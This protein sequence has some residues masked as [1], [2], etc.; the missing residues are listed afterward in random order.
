MSKEIEYETVQVKVPKAVMV[1]L[2][3]VLRDEREVK[4][5]LEYSIIDIRKQIFQRVT[6]VT[7]QI[8]EKREIES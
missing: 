4:K 3:D 6:E 2:R 5:Y 1:F 8:I 7:K